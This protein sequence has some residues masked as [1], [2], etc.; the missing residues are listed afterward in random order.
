MTLQNE[1]TLEQ[2]SPLQ[3]V[4]LFTLTSAHYISPGT[5]CLCANKQVPFNQYKMDILK[6]MINYRR[7]CL[8]NKN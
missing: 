3:L 1:V 2:F 7:S 4:F 8:I 5:T 6:I